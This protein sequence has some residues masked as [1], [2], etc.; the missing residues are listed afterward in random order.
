MEWID[1]NERLPDSIWDKDGYNYR[2][3]FIICFKD[4]TVTFAEFSIT[5]GWYF[6]ADNFD[7]NADDIEWWMK[8]PAPK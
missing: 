3:E 5:D 1:V 7:Y 4:K 8:K 2:D 6:H